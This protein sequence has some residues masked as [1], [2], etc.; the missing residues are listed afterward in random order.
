MLE[1][2]GCKSDSNSNAFTIW[3]YIYFLTA[4]KSCG[5]SE[6]TMEQNQSPPAKVEQG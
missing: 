5:V 2:H 4:L 6:L 3:I 1:I